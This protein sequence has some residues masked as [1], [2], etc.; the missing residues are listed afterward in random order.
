MRRRSEEQEW[1]VGGG[2]GADHA[3]LQVGGSLL[4]HRQLEVVLGRRVSTSNCTTS[5]TSCELQLQHQHKHQHNQHLAGA[6]GE[7]ALPGVHSGDQ[8][9]VGGVKCL[10]GEGEGG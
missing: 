7:D 9:V 8:R 5:T 2:E 10:G 1:I 6:D 3:F 4:H